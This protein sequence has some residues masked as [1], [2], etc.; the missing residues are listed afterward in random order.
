MS[1]NTIIH[2]AAAVIEDAGGIL[3]ARR[4]Q[5]LHQGGLWEFP[6]GKLEPDESAES[7]LRR[8][9]HEELGIT[10]TEL[11]PLLR[12][13]HD[14]GDRQVLL[15]VWRVTGFE[16]EARGMEGQA[17]AWV[18]P[19][20]LDSYEFPAANAPI[21]TACRLPHRYLIT[22]EPDDRD[23]FLD[24]LERSLEQG[25]ELVQLRAKGLGRDGYVALAREALALCSGHGAKL[26]LNGD[27]DLLQE[28]PADGI[29]LSSTRLM[30]LRER[31]EGDVLLAASCHDES[32][33][34]QANRLGLDFIVISPVKQTASHPQAVP[35]GWEGL[36]RLTERARMPAF[37][38][39]GMGGNDLEQAWR[40]GAQGIA[41][42]RG[43]WRP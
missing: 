34:E 14:Y 22:P 7:A 35:L 1:A 10:A 17:I 40:H 8:E 5:H 6:G 31:P 32:E 39:G 38:L 37:A 2:V 11:H 9:L 16:G 43:L 42:I 36:W 15:D 13:D 18:A 21:V 4:P 23:G 3:I 33:V 29:H 28:V 25:I 12:I 27:P 24:A 20:E 26:M 19:R 41:A 30:A